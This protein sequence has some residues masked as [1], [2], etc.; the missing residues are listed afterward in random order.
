MNN[1]QKVT[2]SGIVIF[3][4]SFVGIHCGKADEM[5]TTGFC[6]CVLI[7]IFT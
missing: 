7:W 1:W 4:S 3:A 5:L 2:M 6:I